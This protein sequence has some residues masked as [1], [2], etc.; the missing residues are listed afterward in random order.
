MKVSC[1]TTDC[2]QSGGR[3]LFATHYA[4]LADAHEGSS[5]VASRHMACE[6]SMMPGGREQVRL[7]LVEVRR[8]SGHLTVWP[9]HSHAYAF[10]G[11]VPVQAGGR[12]LPQEL[13]RRVRA[14][15]WCALNRL[16]D[17]IPRESA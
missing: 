11:D 14:L 9:V 4:K 16:S 3:G 5:S 2:T 1:K 10:Q 6:V 8:K 15:C 13:R 17:H 7:T 12:L